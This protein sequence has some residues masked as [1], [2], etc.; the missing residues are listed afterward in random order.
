MLF[1]NSKSHFYQVLTDKY[2]FC[3]LSSFNSISLVTKTFTQMYSVEVKLR[4]MH[5]WSK[6]KAN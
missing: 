5:Y 6:N 1:L 4:A 3:D 2:A